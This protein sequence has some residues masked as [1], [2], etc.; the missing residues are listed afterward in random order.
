MMTIERLIW[1]PNEISPQVWEAMTR[2]EQVDWWK[3]RMAPARPKAPM[4]EAVSLYHEGNITQGEFVT[5]VLQLAAPEEIEDFI[6]ACPPELLAVLR[7]ALASYGDNEA[8]WPRTFRMSSYFPWA[9]PEVIAESNRREQ[10]DIWRGVRL[11][12]LYSFG[13]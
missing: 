10:E 11:L 12:K 6:R 4:T 13:C 1:R 3:A 7:E 9:T 5:L 8:A 2:A